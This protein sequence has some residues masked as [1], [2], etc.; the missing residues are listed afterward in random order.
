METINSRVAAMGL[1]ARVW[2]RIGGRA[3]G[4]EHTVALSAVRYGSEFDTANRRMIR[5]EPAKSPEKW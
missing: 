1:P 4:P 3:V 5:R 2:G